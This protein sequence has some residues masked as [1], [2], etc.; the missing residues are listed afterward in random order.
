M[1]MNAQ[2]YKFGNGKVM[3]WG[4]RNVSTMACFVIMS[5]VTY[6]ATNYL[7]ISPVTVGSLLLASK[8]FDGVTD[9]V[10]GYIVE[11]T[12]TKYGKGRPFDLFIIGVWAG[13]VLMF[14][15]PDLG[16]V[17]KC[18][19]IFLTYT[20]TNAVFFTLLG[21][22]EPVYMM[23]AIPDKAMKE[24]T[25]AIAGVIG[26]VATAVGYMIFP[27]LM[28]KIG[29][30]QKGWIL[31]VLLFAV[32]MTFVGLIRFAA[33]KEVVV[34]DEKKKNQKISFSE[35]KNSLT[36]SKYIYLLCAA[37]ILTTMV[38]NIA[39]TVNT[40]YFNYVIGN[41]ALSS[42]IGVISL[43]TPMVLLFFPS[44]LKKLSISKLVSAGAIIGIV[45][46]LF[47]QFAGENLLLLLLGS[48]L[49][50]VGTLPLSAYS[51][52]M[53]NDVIDYNEKISGLRVEGIF[54][55]FICFAQKVGM[56][57]AAGGVG[58]IMGMNGFISSDASNVVQ[59]P[60]SAI[61]AIISLFGI[62]PA[63]LF[64]GVFILMHFYNIDKNKSS[65]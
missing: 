28:E 5:Y 9:L 4:M 14:A 27:V 22:S 60:Q 54:S 36:T 44:I 33:V 40:Y 61:N 1:I 39:T 62:I 38:G 45:G 23:R 10:A 53:V 65:I 17:G 41:V 50:T 49:M 16:Y 3:L 37:Y 57:L 35:I 21:A 59:Q 64:V 52:V 55:S 20:L 63:V 11:K 32:P 43:V 25:A 19:W 31:L 47:R 30:T 51:I 13:T 29:K 42:L 56:G 46:C 34:D 6:F 58:L 26:V 12:N 8:L 18:V 48:G 7:G 24:K 2:E 15:I